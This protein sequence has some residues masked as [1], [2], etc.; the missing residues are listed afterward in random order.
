[1]RRRVGGWRVRPA[2]VVAAV[3]AAVMVGAAACSTPSTP[4]AAGPSIGTTAGTATGTSR[5]SAS[6]VLPGAATPPTTDAGT[7]SGAGF[8]RVGLPAPWQAAL[9]AG[10]LPHAAG[11]S[12]IVRGVSPDGSRVV[13]DSTVGGNRALEL[14]TDQGR[15][16]SMVATL[17]SATVQVF[18]VSFDGRWL[19]YTTMDVPT[20]ASPWTLYLWDATH[21]TLPPRQLARSTIPGPYPYPLVLAGRVFWTQA[22]AVATTQLHAFDPATGTSRVLVTGVPGAPV[23][24]GSL[25]GWTQM[26]PGGEA[27]T[28]HVADPATGTPVPLPAGLPAQATRPFTLSGDAT[29]AVWTDENLTRLQVLDLATGTVTTVRAHTPAGVF[30]QWPTVAGHLAA[31]DNGQAMYVADLRTHSYTQVTPQGG[32]V[33]LSGSTLSVAYEPTGK[34][35]NPVLDTT[36]VPLTALPALPS[37]G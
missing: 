36:V 28:V 14:L 27:I 22:I 8:C 26:P 15:H 2:A 1:M 23:R 25:L 32:S 19:A 4:V 29:H 5:A 7:S 3:T 33:T 11:E 6:S 35:Q 9:K 30:L 18:G 16:R 21:P 17:P 24:V 12:L 34:S 37:C 20:L 31:W 10:M 13:A